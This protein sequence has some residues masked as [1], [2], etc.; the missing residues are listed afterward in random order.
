MKPFHSIMNVIVI[1][2]CWHFCSYLNIIFISYKGNHMSHHCCLWPRVYLRWNLDTRVFLLNWTKTFN[3]TK[4]TLS[5][6]RENRLYSEDSRNIILYPPQ[7]N[8]LILLIILA[9]AYCLNSND[10]IVLPFLKG[11]AIRE[12]RQGVVLTLAHLYS[13]K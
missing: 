13:L 3:P 7:N 6:Q 2:I 1:F 4:L 10:L 5:S 8:Q 11:I 12:Y 9:T